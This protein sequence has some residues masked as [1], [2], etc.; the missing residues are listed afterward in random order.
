MASDKEVEISKMA[1][2]IQDAEETV[3]E[4]RGKIAGMQESYQANE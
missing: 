3:R 1:A 4:Y 2:Q